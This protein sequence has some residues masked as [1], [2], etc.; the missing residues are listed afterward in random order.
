M[1]NARLQ[2]ELLAGILYL[3]LVFQKCQASSGQ[4]FPQLNQILKRKD[5]KKIRRQTQKY[6]FFHMTINPLEAEENPEFQVLVVLQWYYILVI[7]VNNTTRGDISK[8]KTDQLL[9]A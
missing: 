6:N 3:P 8:L 4:Y 7:V 2:K 5:K 9:Y 1:R